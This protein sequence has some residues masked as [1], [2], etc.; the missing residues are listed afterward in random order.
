M[1]AI[2]I[3]LATIEG[4]QDA[5]FRF[6]QCSVRNIDRIFDKLGVPP[7]CPMEVPQ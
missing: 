7:A 5:R 1:S 6:M 2:E 3:R 4:K